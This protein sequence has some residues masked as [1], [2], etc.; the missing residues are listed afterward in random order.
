MDPHEQLARSITPELY[1]RIR[2]LWIRH[3][4]AEDR[5][6]IPGL[7]ETLTEDCVYEIVSTGQR[8]QGH[9]GAR[10]FYETFLGAFPDV[11]FRLLD[12]VIGP[13]G[14]IEV[15]EMNATHEGAWAGMTPTGKPVC[16][17]VIIHFPWHSVAEKFAGEKVYLPHST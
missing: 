11:Q 9:A 7:L 5:R 10:T 12:I 2:R 3:S 4:L 13:Q 1:Q 14:V 6:D 16:L 17:T 8:W 15:A